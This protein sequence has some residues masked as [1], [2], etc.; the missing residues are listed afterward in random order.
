MRFARIA[1]IRWEKSGSRSLRLL[2]YLLDSEVH[3]FAFSVA[4]NAILSF[5]PFILLLYT[6][7]AAYFHSPGMTAVVGDMAKEFLPSTVKDQDFWNHALASRVP[8]HGVQL[9]SLLMILVACTGIFL[10]LE[11][12]LNRAWGVCKSRNYIVNQLVALG[13]AALMLALGMSCVA[14]NALFR[15]TE[16]S[17]IPAD[18]P[19]PGWS[20]IVA[21]A[22][23]AVLLLTTGVASVLFFFAVYGL[24]P[25]R[26]I[27]AHRAWKAAL[28]TGFL[29]LAARYCFSLLLPHMDLR[30][31]YGPFF[32][33]VEVIFWAYASG[34]ILFSGARLS[35]P[36]E[37]S[38]ASMPDLVAH[39]YLAKEQKMGSSTGTCL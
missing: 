16:K 11:V 6:L 27:P 20:Q 2:R 26:R 18:L 14:G 29:W 38:S 1:W 31:I 7:S 15:A 32:V 30:N 37:G 28:F 22:D 19:L 21:G 25:N 39:K 34:L 10:P 17:W 3:T 9:L 33:S 35:V 23:G 12:A 36:Q 24:L 13:M 4:A 8:R 5:I